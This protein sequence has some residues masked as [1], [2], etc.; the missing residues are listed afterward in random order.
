MSPDSPPIAA[1]SPDNSQL[2]SAP[3]SSTST[4][5]ER[6]S[7]ESLPD[8]VLIDIVRNGQAENTNCMAWSLCLVSKRMEP[9]ARQELYRA[10]SILTCRSLRSLCRT[11][12]DKPELGQYMSAL[13]LIV[14]THQVW[15]C[16]AFGG[17]VKDNFGLFWSSSFEVLMRSTGLRKLTMTVVDHEFYRKL[18]MT[19]VDHEFYSELEQSS[20]HGFTHSLLEA[21]TRSQHSGSITTIL[22]QLEQV[23]LM[24][25]ARDA[26]L[27]TLRDR[28]LVHPEVFK[29]FLHL[30]S[31]STLEC[32]NDSGIWVKCK[33]CVQP[34]GSPTNGTQRSLK[35]RLSTSPHALQYQLLFPSSPSEIPFWR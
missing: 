1:E 14:P 15:S 28:A 18:A 13:N 26:H 3:Q 2:D 7:L 4:T 33:P 11:L 22:P 9:V 31:L 24:S 6:S 10:I 16:N 27:R 29:P 5:L 25:D 34:G 20:Y 17:Q 12:E 35:I 30:P 23:R 21:I 19:M 32:M 8:E